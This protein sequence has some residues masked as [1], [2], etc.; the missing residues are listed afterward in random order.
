MAWTVDVVA[1]GGA[2]T[3]LVAVR[4]R[5]SLVYARIVLVSAW[6]ITVAAVAVVVAS[7]LGRR[8]PRALGTGLVALAFV[9]P[10]AAVLDLSSSVRVAALAFGSAFPL[11]TANLTAGIIRLSARTV[12]VVLVVTTAVDVAAR[13]LLRDP[14]L[15]PDCSA[16]CGRNPLVVSHRPGVV[17]VADLA[18]AVVALGVV[19]GGRC[20]DR[21]SALASACCSGRRGVGGDRRRGGCD[22]LADRAGYEH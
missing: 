22:P 12:T 8:P 10:A 2:L 7:A 14:T 18:V 6:F 11:A 17:L 13:L 15:D 5:W 16:Y 4:D 19:R 1:L 3:V 20:P 9:V 21:R